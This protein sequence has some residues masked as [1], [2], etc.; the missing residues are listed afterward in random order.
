MRKLTDE[1]VD[2]IIHNSSTAD[3]FHYPEW[4]DEKRS[5]MINGENNID[6][7]YERVATRAINSPNP[8]R[9]LVY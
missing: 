4:W 6:P 2:E 3:P 8:I 9:L 1:E 7:D 5:M